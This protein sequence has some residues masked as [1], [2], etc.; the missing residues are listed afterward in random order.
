MK[1]STKVDEIFKKKIA[2]EFGRARDRAKLDG[3]TVENFVAKLGI[4]RAALHKYMTG[5]AIPSLRV[6]EKAKQYWGVNVPYGELG[7]SYLR[8]VRKNAGQME[9]EFLTD[10]SPEQITVKKFTPKGEGTA[11]IILSIDFRKRA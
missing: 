1:R 9:F 10:V 11:E 7:D 4:T 3:W 8:P 6:L 5:T 2:E